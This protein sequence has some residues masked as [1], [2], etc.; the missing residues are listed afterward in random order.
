MLRIDGDLDGY[1][2]AINSAIKEYTDLTPHMRAI[3]DY[4]E[5]VTDERFDTQRTPSGKRWAALSPAYA[6]RKAKDP[7]KKKGAGILV[8]TSRMRKDLK[9]KATKNSVEMGVKDSASNET[10]EKARAHQYGAPKRNIPARPFIG[11]TN[12]DKRE[13]MGILSLSPDR[14]KGKKS[15]K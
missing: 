12:D 3:G 5:S 10:K 15:K 9:K 6:K 7:R 11:L 14:L 2:R 4:L 8:L 13:I 1:K